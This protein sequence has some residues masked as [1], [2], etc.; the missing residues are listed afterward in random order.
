M[1]VSHY[2]NSHPARDPEREAFLRGFFGSIGEHVTI[3]DN[4][5]IGANAVVLQG[6]T[7]GENSVIAAGAVV[8]K[9]VPDNCLYGGVP[10]RLIKEIV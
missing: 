10:A 5:W 7:I 2:I 8:N 4:A 3:K 9:D 1:Y 6:V